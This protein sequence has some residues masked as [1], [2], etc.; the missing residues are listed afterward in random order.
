MDAENGM[1]RIFM[2]HMQH[3]TMRVTSME[4]SRTWS[5]EDCDT[6]VFSDGGMNNIC[7]VDLKDDTVIL[8]VEN[9]VPGM[10][11]YAFLSRMNV[12]L[13]LLR[14]ETI[15]LHTGDCFG[16]GNPMNN[17]TSW[18]LVWSDFRKLK[19]MPRSREC[20][21]DDKSTHFVF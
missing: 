17:E 21:L 7:S 10:Q 4:A 5:D 16:H 19:R 2:T 18:Y 8:L 3:I 11:V 12:G 6:I 20:L 1:L 13:E 15:A 9:A 14:G